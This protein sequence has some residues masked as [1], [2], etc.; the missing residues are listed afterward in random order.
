MEDENNN[1]SN[2]ERNESFPWENKL[3]F[4]IREDEELIILCKL[5]ENL[6][7]FYEL[8]YTLNVFTHEVNDNDN[9]QT[10]TLC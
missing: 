10:E 4:K 3:A 9:T 5:F 2:S 8:D 1:F 6:L 7:E